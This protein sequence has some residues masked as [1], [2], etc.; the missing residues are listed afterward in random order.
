MLFVEERPLHK[1]FTIP[2]LPDCN[3]S[4]KIIFIAI[5]IIVVVVVVC[6]IIMTKFIVSPLLAVQDL[7]DEKPLRNQGLRSS[8]DQSSGEVLNELNWAQLGFC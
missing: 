6:L 3:Q 7:K 2:P 5:F 8:R 4:T 1:S